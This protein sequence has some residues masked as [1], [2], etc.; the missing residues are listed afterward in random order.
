MENPNNVKRSIRIP[1]DIND[2]LRKI[3]KEKGCSANRVIL[4]ILKEKI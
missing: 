4:D 1:I 3:A 2:K